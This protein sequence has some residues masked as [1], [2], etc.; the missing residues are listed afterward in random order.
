MTEVRTEEHDG[1]IKVTSDFWEVEHV[2][3]AGGAWG[4]LV[5]K[6]GSG[7]NLRST[8]LRSVGTVTS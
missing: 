7:K 5:F 3:R 6:N 2:R 8:W 1:G 4:S